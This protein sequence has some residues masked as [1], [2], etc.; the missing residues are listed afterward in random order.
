MDNTV[1]WR[2][3]PYSCLDGIE[4][5]TN[6]IFS[7][8]SDRY[9]HWRTG[10]RGKNQLIYVVVYGKKTFWWRGVR[11]IAVSQ[12]RVAAAAAIDVGENKIA[13]DCGMAAAKGTTTP[14]SPTRGQCASRRLCRDMQNVGESYKVLVLGDSNVGK[15]CLMHRFCDETYYDTY[16]STIGKWCKAPIRR[17]GVTIDCPFNETA[18]TVPT[19][20]RLPRTHESKY[21]TTRVKKSNGIVLRTGCLSRPKYAYITW[22]CQNRL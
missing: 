20:G 6:L 17:C 2:A 19:Q 16:I 12:Q 11:R 13:I 8:N 4:R 3:G 1:G 7:P 10:D 22:T 9:R 21:M 15:T 5:E 18:R 14:P